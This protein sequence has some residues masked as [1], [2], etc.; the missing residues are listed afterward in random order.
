[1]QLEKTR[2]SLLEDFMEHIEG[3]KVIRILEA[4]IPLY[5]IE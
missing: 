5:S 1:M 3:K 2:H 4:L